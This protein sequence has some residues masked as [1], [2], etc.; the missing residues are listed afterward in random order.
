MQQGVDCLWAL[1]H[2]HVAAFLNDFQEGEQQ[3]LKG[4]S[5]SCHQCTFLVREKFYQTMSH[6][7]RHSINITVPYYEHCA[8]Y[9]TVQPSLEQRAL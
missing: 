5:V 4:G 1:H 7:N 9:I 2:H 6:M 3:D 8:G